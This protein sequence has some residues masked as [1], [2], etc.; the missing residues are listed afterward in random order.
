M[1]IVKP[2]R[3][4]LWI[5]PIAL[6]ALAGLV[7]NRPKPVSADRDFDKDDV[8]GRYISAETF[9]D[10]ST[11]HAFPAAINSGIVG[12]AENVASAEVLLADGEGNVCGEVDGFYPGIDAPGSNTGPQYYHGTYKVAHESGRIEIT[13]C[14]DATTVTGICQDSSPC[15]PSAEGN[16]TRLQV[17]YI[18]GRDGNKMVTVSQFEAGYPD[19]TGFVVHTRNWSKASQEGDHH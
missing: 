9:Y 19:S 11:V 13:T 10:E 1:R 6:L 15:P 12:P 3:Y 7:W 5:L 4:Y 8:Q 18:Q 16:S 17:G 14:S 2:S